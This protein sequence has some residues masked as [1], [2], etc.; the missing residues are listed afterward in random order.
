MLG[1]QLCSFLSNTMLQLFDVNAL[2]PAKTAK[3]TNGSTNT[4]DIYADPKLKIPLKFSDP[5]PCP[6][7]AQNA[8]HDTIAPSHTILIFN[9]CE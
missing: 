7:N 4:T 5:N 2:T 8:T 3:S 9:I 1:E 6:Y